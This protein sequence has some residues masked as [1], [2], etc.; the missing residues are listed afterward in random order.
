MTAAHAPGDDL[1]LLATIA[2]GIVDLDA[3]DHVEA[4]TMP[5]PDTAQFGLDRL[6]LLCLFSGQ[7]PPTGIPDLI[8]WGWQK[9]LH[10]WPLHAGHDAGHP[11]DLLV[12]P[13]SRRPTRLCLA[14]A[15][16]HSQDGPLDLARSYLQ[17]LAEKCGMSAATDLAIKHLIENPAITARRKTKMAALPRIGGLWHLMADLYRRAPEWYF[18]D[19]VAATCA[20]CGDLAV[21]V[22][23]D[24]WWCPWDS[25]QG[26]AVTVGGELDRSEG[27]WQLDGV[28]RWY[29]AMSG[30]RVIALRS[31]LV[32]A[33]VHETRLS[34]DVSPWL[35]VVTRAG[36]TWSVLIDDRYK[37]R[38]TAAAA[39]RRTASNTACRRVVA[40]PD[41]WA[42]DLRL[43][44]LRVLVAPGTT[45]MTD[46]ELIA[47]A[48]GKATKD[49]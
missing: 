31:R 47:V 13:L 7:E 19:G 21:P 32:E 16:E 36:E 38:L 6:S 45:A 9:P 1:E 42:E 12:D 14:W 26:C 49:A 41:D 43:E 40:V 20:I 27:A 35:E 15:L 4:F 3:V 44:Q 2:Q 17:V 8:R 18:R 48:T 5:Y 33:G 23:G 10:E 11:A 39:L 28:L 46:S 22:A 37:P 34:L 24:L 25:P 29:F 30:R